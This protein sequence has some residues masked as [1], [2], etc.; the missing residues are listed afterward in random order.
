M[1]GFHAQ[2]LCSLLTVTKS[3]TSQFSKIYLY[4]NTI[5]LFGFNLKCCMWL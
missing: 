3:F 2:D 1:G 4:N 5:G